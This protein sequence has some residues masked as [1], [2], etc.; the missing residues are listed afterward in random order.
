[1]KR[2]DET[3]LVIRRVSPWSVLRISALLYISLFAMA[4]V[5]STFL[6]WTA[7]SSGW[8]GNVESLIG[9]LFYAGEFQLKGGQMF[10]AVLATGV[11]VVGL[12]CGAN[13]VM[14]V[15][16]NLI[17]DLVGGVKL[18]V[19]GGERSPGPSAGADPADDRVASS[20]TRRESTTKRAELAAPNRARQPR[21]TRKQG[22]AAGRPRVGGSAGSNRS[23]PRPGTSP[24]KPEIPVRLARRIEPKT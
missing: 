3:Q 21:P 1:M 7:T 12:G 23:R 8:R 24:A 9:D 15:L 19:A 16:F 4:L 11:A 14:A 22:K 2:A 10:R 5:A 18:V 13:V 6:W 20:P 17:S